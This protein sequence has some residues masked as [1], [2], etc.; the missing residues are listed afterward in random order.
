MTNICIVQTKKPGALIASLSGFIR[1]VGAQQPKYVEHGASQACGGEPN[2]DHKVL[3]WL[4][5]STEHLTKGELLFCIR[6]FFNLWH[7]YVQPRTAPTAYSST[8]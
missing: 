5:L 2:S 3:F 6:V 8:S 1:M 7:P 4:W